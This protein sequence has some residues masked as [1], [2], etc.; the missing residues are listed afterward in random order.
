MRNSFQTSA[1]SRSYSISCYAGAPKIFKRC[2]YFS[3]KLKSNS[4]YHVVKNSTWSS[5]LILSN[6]F[7]IDIST[8][9]NMSSLTNT[10]LDILI[11][12][13]RKFDIVGLEAIDIAVL[14]VVI[15]IAKSKKYKKM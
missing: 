1:K 5:C 10:S 11:I 13:V 4:T 9:D 3:K 14:F 12:L 7:N 15:F 8:I 2:I 6:I